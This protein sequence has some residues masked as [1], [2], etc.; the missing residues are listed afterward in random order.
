MPAYSLPAG[1]AIP[2]PWVD[3]VFWW[4]GQS[5]PTRGILDTGA[6]Y[7][8]VP[9]SIAQALRLRPTGHQT[10]LSANNARTTSR[11]Y[12]VDVEFDGLSFP[13]IEVVGSPLPV[14]LIGRDILNTLVAKF[15]GPAQDYSLDPS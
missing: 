15:D 13:Q 12:L 10:F 2:G 14:A 1:G 4:S 8:Q 11:L 9:E 5:R 3:V 7:T 6:D